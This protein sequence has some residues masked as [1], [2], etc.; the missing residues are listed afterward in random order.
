MFGEFYNEGED[1]AGIERRSISQVA[2]LFERLGFDYVPEGYPREAEL[3]AV[4]ADRRRARSLSEWQEFLKG[5][6]VLFVHVRVA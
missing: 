3:N 6:F 5:C 2:D 4:L 1:I